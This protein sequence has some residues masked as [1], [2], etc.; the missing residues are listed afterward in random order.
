MIGEKLGSY[1]VVQ[2]IGE[3]GMGAVYV[4]EHELLS[5]K[6]AI[7]V[8]LPMLSNDEELVQRFFNEA[9][10]ATVINHAGIVQV[11]DFGTTA[12]GQAFLVMEFLEGEALEQRLE[13]LGRLPVADALRIVRHC[14]GALHAA[15]EVG[16][17]HRDLKPDNIFL[18]PDPQVEGGERSKILDFGIAKL[19]DERQSGSVKTRTGSLMGTPTYMAPEQC[20]GAGEV[21]LR[22]DIYSMG[23]VLFHLVSGRPP[24][25]GAG[26]GEVLAAHLREPA[27]PVRAFAPDVPPAV[28]ALIARTLAKEPG[29]RFPDMKA[30][31]AAITAAAH[32]QMP[33]PVG[34]APLGPPQTLAVGGG[35]LGSG[36]GPVPGSYPGQGPVPGSYPGQG[37]VPGSYPGQGMHSGHGSY[38]GQGQGSG[39]M[40]GVTSNQQGP[41]PVTG[42]TLGAAA[43]QNLTQGTMPGARRKRTA[44]IAGAA[45][46]TLAG[47]LAAVLVVGSGGDDDEEPTQLAAIETP[48]D[49]AEVALATPIDA[50][51][52]VAVEVEEPDAAPPQIAIEVKT[53][54][55]GATV[56]LGDSDEPLGTT[57]YTY[58]AAASSEVLS[59]RLER[60]G[61]ETEEV[62]FEGDTN[63]SLRLSLS[64][65]RRTPTKR[66]PKKPDSPGGDELLYR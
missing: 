42:S 46:A 35:A 2:K 9:K 32:G 1:R 12:S 40:P 48:A 18:V 7:K 41:R 8:L 29:D 53:R 23:C 20:R 37:P 43:A 3:G 24:F 61:Y 26:V 51:V 30:F 66:P 27:P 54:P 52:A 36:Q 47:V 39:V 22:A 58:E 14:A 63:Q 55:P 4:G 62:E 19:T 21:D 6:A 25:V 17:V 59:F 33:Q 34:G 15:H 64:R 60:D 38:P 13:R 16:I 45:V 50:A 56:F 10:A 5:R 65:K 44:L 57:P 11:F 28:E 49:A 31:S